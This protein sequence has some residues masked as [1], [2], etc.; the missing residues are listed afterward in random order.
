LLQEVR[1]GTPFLRLTVDVDNVNACLQNSD[2]E[3]AS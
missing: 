1:H 2:R 3:M